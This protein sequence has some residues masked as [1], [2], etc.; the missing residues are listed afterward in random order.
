[1]NVRMPVNTGN[2]DLTQTTVALTASLQFDSSQQRCL[3]IVRL[4]Q[5]FSVVWKLDAN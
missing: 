3:K 1:M 4:E 5:L 2:M